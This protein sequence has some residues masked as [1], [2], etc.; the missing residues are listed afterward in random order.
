MG[1]ISAFRFL[2]GM[3]F[4]T[5]T[6]VLS[7]P[8]PPMSSP[9]L[10]PHT[11]MTSSTHTLTH[12]HRHTFTHTHTL[13]HTDTLT[14]CFLYI[15]DFRAADLV[16]VNQLR[17]SLGKTVFPSLSKQSIPDTSPLSVGRAPYH[18]STPVGIVLVQVSFRW[19][20]WASWI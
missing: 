15:H 11:L 17:G 5:Y 16:Y 12:S 10:L 4:G 8:A 1:T 2:Q 20:C 9:A 7:P 13:T 19:Q 14:Q 3:V 6:C 18:I